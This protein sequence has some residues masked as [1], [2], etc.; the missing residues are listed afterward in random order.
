[1]ERIPGPDDLTRAE[2]ELLLKLY[3]GRAG[4]A[5]LVQAADK[6]GLS[7]V[8]IQRLSGIARTSVARMLNNPSET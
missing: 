5:R 2:V 1:M 4:Q 6:L 8:Q 3:G 7:A